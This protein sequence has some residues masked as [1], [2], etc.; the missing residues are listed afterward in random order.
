[1]KSAL[2]VWGGWEGH[3]PKQCVDIFAPYLEEQGYEVEVSN[4][5]DTYLD[6]DKMKAL[7]L[8]VPVWTMGT[9]TGEQ[10][11]GLLE[12]VKSGVGIA[13]WHG[14]MGDSFRMNTE[15]Q[16]MVGG[17]WVAHPGGIVSY[18]VHIVNHDDPITAGLPDFEMISEQYYMHVDPSNEVLATTTF[19]GEDA[20]WIEGC[21]MPVVW[22]RMWG[23]GRVFYTSLGHVA[24]DFEVPEA[25]EI[26]QR[27]LLWASR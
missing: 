25:L 21:V 20:P 19:S 6:A 22:K 24:K 1:M 14:G 17:Q 26:V 4:T 10:Q 27:G 12:A 2:L 7:S 13:G 23:K 3:E 11:K 9:I 8:I 16:F 18:D 15:Y 5:L